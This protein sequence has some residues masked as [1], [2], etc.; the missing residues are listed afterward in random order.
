MNSKC[1]NYFLILIAFISIFFVGFQKP[2]YN[3]D[4]TGYTASIYH[5]IGFRGEE[6]SRKTYSDLK[7]S[8]PDEAFEKIISSNEYMSS[9]YADP[10][11]LEQQIP[12]YKIRVV[13]LNL[14][15]FF[16]ENLFNNYSEAMY[17]LG[18]L[19]AGFASIVAGLILIH[20]KIS[21]LFLFP[22]LFVSG[23]VNLSRLSTPDSLAAFI[24]LI[25]FYCSF[26]IAD[27]KTKNSTHRNKI[28][29]YATMILI[30]SFLPSIRTDFII[31]S[32]LFLIFFL[33][34]R[35]IYL[36]IYILISLII[37]GL[38]NF[39]AENYG[40]LTIFNFTLIDITPYPAN[41]ILSTNPMDYLNAYFTGALS[42][43]NSRFI[44]VIFF[45]LIFQYFFLRGYFLYKQGF[46]FDQKESN[47]LILFAI[48]FIFISLHFVL[49]PAVNIRN[50]SPFIFLIFTSTILSAKDISIQNSLK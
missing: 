2:H 9:V 46:N 38:V 45:Y 31:L 1:F 39:Y 26:K 7:G 22:G 36:G 8:M 29:L 18:A 24:T 50:Y 23:F 13:Y 21:N 30:L 40:Y 17:F 10:V 16:G 19:F 5:M 34:N 49:F 47:Y 15:K 42:L 28:F 3:W 12:F 43:I 27:L 41:K 37:Y 35:K 44:L 32:F 48:A 33:N 25:L 20:F 14:A 11:S 4:I 6:L